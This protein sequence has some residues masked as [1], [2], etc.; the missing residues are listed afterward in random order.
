[1]LGYSKDEF[2]QMGILDVE[3]SLNEKSLSELIKDLRAKQVLQ[4]E[5]KHKKK[6]KTVF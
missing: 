5:S 2:L 6:N 1:M 4:L 3:I